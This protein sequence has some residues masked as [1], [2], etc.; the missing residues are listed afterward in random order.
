MNQARNG[1]SLGKQSLGETRQSRAS[2]VGFCLRVVADAVIGG[3]FDLR[4]GQILGFSEVGEYAQVLLNTGA[5]ELV[6]ERVGGHAK[7]L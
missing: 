5:C 7:L 3:G 1:E 4:F 6:H 2:A